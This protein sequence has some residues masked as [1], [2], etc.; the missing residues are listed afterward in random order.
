[1]EIL[2]I[3]VAYILGLGASYLGLPPLVGYLVGGF[4]LGEWEIG[5]SPAIHIIA[6][7]G[8]LLLLFSVGLK[9]NFKSLLNW[10]VLGI[11]ITYLIVTGAGFT[12]LFL[13]A[14]IAPSPAVFL[15]LGLAFSSTVFA[16]KVLEEKSEIGAF[17][18]RLAI[19]ILIVQDLVA[20]GMLVAVE[21]GTFS[22]WTLFFLLC[23]PLLRSPLKRIL[24]WSGH[25]ELLL[26]YGL[27]IALGGS[28]TFE[29]MGL[30]AELG[31]LVAGMLLAD[32]SRSEELSKTLW[33]LKE[34]F[35]VGFFLQIGLGGLPESQDSKWLLLLITLLPLRAIV[36]FFFGTLF[37]LRARTAFLTTLALFSYSE[38]LLIDVAAAIKNGI[39]STTW[40]PTLALLVTISLIIAAPLNRAS[41]ALFAY[42]EWWLIRFE[43]Q[44]SHPEGEPP[45]IKQAKWLV[46]GMGRAGT[47]AYNFLI[48]K[49]QRVWGLDSDPVIVQQ[50]LEE[51]RRVIYG[52]AEDPDLLEK[53]NIKSLVG[54]ILGMP[55]LEAKLRFSKS[56]RQN[57]F[58]GMLATM[59]L[60]PEEDVKLSENGV[61]LIF[62]PFSEIGERLAERALTGIGSVAFKPL[63]PNLTKK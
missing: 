61:N 34:V 33:G 52:D 28:H 15:G 4:I 9:L 50:H 40:L 18:G 24:T 10:E 35:L 14:E 41:H 26:L 59:S 60:Y 19:G 54:V 2:W 51:K 21:G 8:V 31:A 16:A 29:S 11:G 49:H 7:T 36:Y 39:L 42:F 45:N 57:G 47:A 37:R 20:V 30:S 48:Q 56:L 58:Q 32:H 62:H 23:I 63:L 43:R 6:E 12:L 5:E 38:F 25:S 17:H 53:I 1:M 55:D 3:A 22:L 44:V 27:F 46:I 13:I